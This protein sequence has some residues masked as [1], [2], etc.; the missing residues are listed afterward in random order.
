MKKLFAI[1]MSIMMIACFMPTMAFAATSAS[2]GDAAVNITGKIGEQISSENNKVTITLKN[3]ESDNVNFIETLTKTTDGWI[4]GIPDDS[5]IRY[6]VSKKNNTQVE[7]TFAGTP[8][9][10][11]P[12]TTLTIQ[13]PA[14]QLT[15]KPSAP[16]QVSGNVKLTITGYTVTVTEGTG[17][18]QTSGNTAAKTQTNLGGDIAMKA[19]S[20]TANE[21]YYFP[22]PYTSAK[23]ENGITVARTSATTITVSGIPK[24]DVTIKLAAATA[25]EKEKTPTAT[26]TA[27][28]ENGGTLGNVDTTMK[29]SV[30]GG[31]EWN[32]VTENDMVIT[33]VTK[34]NDVKVKKTATNVVE[35]LDSDVQT[36]DVT[37]NDVPSGVKATNCTS[38]DNDGKLTGVTTAMEYKKD[39]AED[40]TPVE[41]DGVINGLAAGTYY[42]RTKAAGTALASTNLK[43]EIKGYPTATAKV[44]DVIKGITTVEL[45]AKDITITLASAKLNGVEKGNDVSAW[46]KTLPAGLKATVKKV[47]DNTEVTITISGTPTK[48]GKATAKI[49]IPKNKLVDGKEGG[50]P[51]ANDVTFSIA[52]Y[53]HVV[54]GGGGGGAAAKPAQPTTPEQKPAT[55]AT[56]T[57]ANTAITTAAAANKYDKAEQAEVDQIV[58]EAEA[59][60]KEAKTEDEVKAIQKDA[61]TKLDKILTTEEKATIAS[62]KEVSK[63]DFGTKSKKITKKNGK[64]AVKL[65]WAA[66]EGVDVDGYEIFRSTKKN[67]GYG[68]E[69]YFET[70]KTSYT[71]SKGLKS[72]KTYYYRVRAYVEINGERHYTDYSTKASRKI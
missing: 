33:G 17:M 50:L 68:T 6:T 55:A 65:S 23:E 61:E 7:I 13:I 1:L 12:E 9:K 71:N 32:D 28:S 44:P 62:L 39:N 21:G 63:R 14:D 25:K 45:E 24:A 31:T 57:A 46:F 5:G 27:T 64:K 66:P 38:A 42:V 34:D 51:V 49:T 8:S 72:G 20:F 67:S 36:I 58:K 70:P 35:K 40:W 10:V 26:F 54:T 60:I 16:L 3:T 37:Q 53:Y 69:P 43:L 4:T 47:T 2:V 30:N 22:D 11:V 59:K 29:Y 52:K 19:L 56:K 15:T 18:A 41:N 48:E